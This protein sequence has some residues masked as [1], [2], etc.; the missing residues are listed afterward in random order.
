MPLGWL[1]AFDWRRHELEKVRATGRQSCV[2]RLKLE[3][4]LEGKCISPV[5][6]DRP[7]WETASGDCGPV[8]ADI[9]SDKHPSEDPWLAG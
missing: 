6:A 8:F 1:D 2:T 9:A 7:A 3:G 5:A 4:N